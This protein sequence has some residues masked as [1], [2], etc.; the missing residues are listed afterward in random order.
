M[1]RPKTPFPLL[2]SVFAS[3]EFDTQFATL[4]RQL[5][6]TWPGL[7]QVSLASALFNALS[8]TLFAIHETPKRSKVQGAARQVFLREVRT[9][10][11]D[12]TTLV[13]QWI[14]PD[15]QS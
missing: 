6:S 14:G 15:D 13:V 2:N 3:K 12:L 4:M 1:N 11:G 8:S 10:L 5:V 9:A 7:N